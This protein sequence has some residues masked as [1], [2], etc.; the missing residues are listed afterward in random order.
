M[1]RLVFNHD[2]F[3]NKRNNIYFIE[4]R[5]SMIK[6]FNKFLMISFLGIMIYLLVFHGMEMSLSKV[7][8]TLSILPITFVPF[9]VSKIFHYKVSEEIKCIYYLFLLIAMILGSS[10]GFYYKISWFD[11]LAHFLSGVFTSFLSLI[12]MKK[13]GLLEAKNKYFIVLYMVAITLT[14]ASLWEFFEF[15]S[16]KL[17][18]GDVQWVEET[19]V[20][21]T[22][23]DMLIA[24]LGS[25]LYS[26]YFLIR[27]KSKEYLNKLNSIF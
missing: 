10:L 1:Y 3:L 8:T 7:L 19:G 25:I 17:L 21:D 12:L 5:D 11:L 18:N 9:L 4:R 26:I 24:F 15:T 20:D 6:K 14:I 2:W 27:V 13:K 23:G 22:M 16:D